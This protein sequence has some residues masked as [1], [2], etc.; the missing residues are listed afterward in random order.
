[1]LFA[2][3]W[4][5]SLWVETGVSAMA[6]ARSLT[7]VVVGV[8]AILLIATLVTRRPNV[9][10]VFTIAGFGLLISRDSFHALAIATLAV[11]VPL[12]VWQWARMR[13]RPFSWQ[14]LTRALNL[15]CALILGLV[16]VG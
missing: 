16:I 12:T 11:T 15:F 3:A 10:G 1:I 7:I 9:A 6:M 5:L 2:A 14:R 4:V 8:G 13:G